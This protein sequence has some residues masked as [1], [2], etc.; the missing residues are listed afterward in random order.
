MICG[1]THG[2]QM[3][4]PFVGGVFTPGTLKLFPKYD[5]GYFGIGKMDLI[6]SSGL[7]T[8]TIPLRLFCRPEI[9]VID[10]QGKLPYQPKKKKQ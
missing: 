3:R 6:I 10:L 9:T 1:H 5:M 7:G 4:I 8:S 2:G